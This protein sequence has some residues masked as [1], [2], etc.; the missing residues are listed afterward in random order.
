MR[1]YS[2]VSPHN[3]HVSGSIALSVAATPWL[4]NRLTPSDGAVPICGQDTTI[5]PEVKTMPA[6]AG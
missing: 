5:G 6:R 1:I 2:S 3:S 4:T